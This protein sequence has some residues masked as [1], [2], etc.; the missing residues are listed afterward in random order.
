MIWNNNN[1][2]SKWIYLL[3]EFNCLIN[4]PNVNNLSNKLLETPNRN[5][6]PKFHQFNLQYQVNNHKLDNKLNNVNKICKMFKV[7]YNLLDSKLMSWILLFNNLKFNFKIKL[8]N[9]LIVRVNWRTPM[10]NNLFFR[11]R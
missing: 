1:L 8:K 9:H 10:N 11:K 3:L 7:D 5:V 2:H 6:R 4:K